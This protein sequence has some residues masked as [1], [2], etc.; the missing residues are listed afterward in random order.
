MRLRLRWSHGHWWDEPGRT[1]FASWLSCQRHLGLE[2]RRCFQPRFEGRDHAQ[3]G[4]Y[5]NSCSSGRARSPVRSWRN[6]IAEIRQ[7]CNHQGAMLLTNPETLSFHRRIS[8]WTCGLLF[9]GPLLCGGLTI[10]RADAVSELASF[11]VFDK[12]DLVQ[13]AK[14]DVKTAHGPP[15]RN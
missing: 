10:A 8:A 7:I 1:T 2:N 14:S 11:S 12:V 15:M 9:L 13:L 4:R 6:V 5:R 3:H